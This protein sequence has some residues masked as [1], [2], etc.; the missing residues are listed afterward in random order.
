MPGKPT[1]WLVDT[2]IFMNVLDVPGFNQDRDRVLQDFEIRYNQGDSFLLPFTSIIEVGNHIGQ[3]SNSNFRQQFA[4]KYT[5]QVYQALSG[6]APWKPL[7]FPSPDDL[8]Q[9]L[10]NFPNNAQQGIGVGDH[11]IIKQWE[12]RC[13]QSMAYTV[14]IWNTDHHLQ[15]YECNH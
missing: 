4:Q 10:Q 6:I 1:I 9:W 7:T 14:K 3:L 13:S 15:G 8:T 2:S 12:D 11:I 5:E